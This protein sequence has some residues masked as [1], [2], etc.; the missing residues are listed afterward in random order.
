M[1]FGQWCVLDINSNIKTTNL[2]D[3]VVFKIE[4]KIWIQTGAY[5]YYSTGWIIAT[6]AL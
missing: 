4:S 1:H 5:L 6:V 2:A 3:V